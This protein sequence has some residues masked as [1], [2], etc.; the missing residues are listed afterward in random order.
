LW[1][2]ADI[3][4]R[5]PDVRFARDSGPQSVDVRIQPADDHF[6][7]GSG[8]AGGLCRRP[9]MTKS[10]TVRAHQPFG[11]TSCFWADSLS[12]LVDPYASQPTKHMARVRGSGQSL[13]S[14]SSKSSARIVCQFWARSSVHTLIR[15]PPRL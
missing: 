3:P 9:L 5:S 14:T 6:G 12:L 13:I 7:V 2:L 11:W 1:L 10:D 15:C 4:S 8:H